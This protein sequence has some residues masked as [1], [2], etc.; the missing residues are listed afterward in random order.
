MVNKVDLLDPFTEKQQTLYEI[1]GE[2]SEKTN[3]II[4]QVNLIDDAVLTEKI[5]AQGVEIAAL[6][7]E[8]VTKADTADTLAGYGITDAYTKA[9]VN[10]LSSGAG[11]ATTLA[12]YGITDAYTDAETNDLLALKA[13][14]ADLATKADINHTH[15]FTDITAKP[16]TY[17]PDIHTH[18]YAAIT[19]KPTTFPPATHSHDF[20]AI[21]G[22]PA[23]YPPDVHTHDYAAITGKPTTFTPTA[24]TH[25]WVDVTSKPATYPPDAH[26]HAWTEITA[27]PTTFTPNLMSGTTVGGAIVGN[28]L[29]MSGSYLYLKA[30]RGLKIDTAD[31]AVVIDRAVSDT[32]YV[33][34]GALALTNITAF[35]NGY[36]HLTGKELKYA[37]TGEKMLWLNGIV[38]GAAATTSATGTVIATLPA[39]LTPQVSARCVAA[40]SGDLQGMID[41]NTDGTIKIA[42]SLTG[43]STFK[44][45]VSIN[46]MVPLA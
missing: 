14:D 45:W 6:T 19:G 16:A 34:K 18:D 10:A 35:S 33:G 8:M 21:T 1:I 9:E 44:G 46:V 42:A 43:V 27:K 17:P 29:G 41:V 20:T 25:P 4:D 38:D 2:L 26:S 22:R 30:L 40:L 5:D 15:T 37:V 11:G 23:T 28:G 12:G 31:N 3:E 32:W 39:G 13:D 24:H 36:T 7:E